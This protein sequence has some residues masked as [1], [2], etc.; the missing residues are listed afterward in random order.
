MRPIIGMGG[1]GTDPIDGVRFNCGD[2]LVQPIGWCWCRIQNF[3]I[4][5]I[6]VASV[7]SEWNQFDGVKSN[8][9]KKF[10]DWC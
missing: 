9:R 6:A 1:S 7:L 2:F 5:F 4:G 3:A 10:I 8:C